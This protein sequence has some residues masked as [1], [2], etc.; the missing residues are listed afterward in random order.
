[1]IFIAFACL[2]EPQTTLYSNIAS[3]DGS[4]IPNAQIRIYTDEETVFAQTQSDNEGSFSVSLPS[5]QTFFVVINHPEFMP[6]SFT[7]LAGEGDTEFESFVL[8]TEA[9]FLE[10]VQLYQNCEIQG[11]YIE[12]E[13][14]VGIPDQEIDILPIV[15]TASAIAFNTDLESASACYMNQDSSQTGEAGRYLVTQLREGLHEIMLTVQYSAQYQE[16]FYY[17]TYVPENGRANL[18]PTL[19]PL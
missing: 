6:Q 18:L 8:E 10:R 19:I 1:M 16:E 9:V 2:S 5:F 14:R 3:E 11:G 12:G 4:R 15:T 17:M 7:G 13:V